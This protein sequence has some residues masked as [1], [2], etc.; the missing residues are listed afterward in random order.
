MGE[1]SE[2]RPLTLP[3]PRWGEEKVRG[4]GKGEKEGIRA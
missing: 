1:T 3:S 4:G 2:R